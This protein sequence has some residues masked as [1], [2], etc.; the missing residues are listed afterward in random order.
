M[1]DTVNNLD[2]GAPLNSFTPLSIMYP[3][4]SGMLVTNSGSFFF[5]KLIYQFRLYWYFFLGQSKIPNVISS[6]PS[7]KSI[8]FHPLSKRHPT[9]H[10]PRVVEIGGAAH[11]A[12]DTS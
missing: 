2:I 5:K 7:I 4:W 6:E 9:Y 8:T 12:Q 3:N 1:Q 11:S 10:Q